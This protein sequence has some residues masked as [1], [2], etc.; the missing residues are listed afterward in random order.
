ML[1]N[2]SDCVNETGNDKKKFPIGEKHL[3]SD[4]DFEPAK[5]GAEVEL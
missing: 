3:K 2:S 4:T 1:A 5:S